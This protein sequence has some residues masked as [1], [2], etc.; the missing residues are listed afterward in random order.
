[1]KMNGQFKKNSFGDTRHISEKLMVKKTISPTKGRD[2]LFFFSFG[3]LWPYVVQISCSFSAK[4]T[5]L[6]HCVSAIFASA[7][8]FVSSFE[9]LGLSVEDFLARP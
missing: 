9:V 8:S 2:V 7:A 5:D 4:C 6:G 1:M 3:L